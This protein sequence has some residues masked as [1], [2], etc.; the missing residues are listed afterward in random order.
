MGAA[1]EPAQAANRERE[2]EKKKKTMGSCPKMTSPPSRFGVV[3][4]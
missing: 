1:L 4:D 2:R 3:R